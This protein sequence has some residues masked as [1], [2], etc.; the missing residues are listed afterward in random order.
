MEASSLRTSGAATQSEAQVA[1]AEPRLNFIT[2]YQNYQR[3]WMENMRGTL[4]LVATVIATMTFQIAINPP[5]GVWQQ[6]MNSQNGCPKQNCTAGTSVLAYYDTQK[7]YIEAFLIICTISFSASLTIIL[8]LICGF[9][10]SNRVTMWALI[11]AMCISVFFTAAAYIISIRMVLQGPLAY[12]VDTITLYYAVYWGGLIALVFLVLLS[13]LV[14]WLMK[15]FLVT[16]CKAIFFLIKLVAMLCKCVFMVGSRR[17][18][19][20]PAAE[21]GAFPRTTRV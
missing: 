10:L 19:E 17:S 1:A 5:G 6:T 4:M 2:R 21:V 20:S 15:K 11:I 9:P 13:R 18:N 3:D 7:I 16:L 14:F 12:I 8:L